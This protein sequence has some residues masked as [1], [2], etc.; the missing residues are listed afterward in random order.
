MSKPLQLEFLAATDRVDRMPDS[1]AEIVVVGRSNVGKSSLLNA[2]GSKSVAP[3]SKSPGRT[4]TL[5]CFA[6]GKTGGTLVDCPGYGFAKAPQAVRD[7]W[8]PMITE[9]LLAREPLVMV[10]V[11]VDGEIGPTV[12]DRSML[13]WL[14]ENDLPCTVVATK[15]DK[16]K[17]SMRDKRARELA[18]RCAVPPEQV[19]WVSA[20]KGSGL[21]ALRER[22]HEWLA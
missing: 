10:L 19:L 16:V 2:L 4:Q 7:G 20:A 6:V 8:L 22:I 14:R 3:V 21:P 11:L 15:H 9:Y 13:N 1:R 5:G 18:S 17:P 12:D